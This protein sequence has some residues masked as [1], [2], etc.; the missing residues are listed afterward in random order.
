MRMRSLLSVSII[1]RAFTAEFD[2]IRELGLD[3]DQNVVLLGDGDEQPKLFAHLL[4]RCG[5]RIIRVLAPLVV[6]VATAAADR[7]QPGPDAMRDGRNR[8]E[9][10]AAFLAL[11][12]DRVN[13]V[14]GRRDGGDVDAGRARGLA[15]GVGGCGVD[16]QGQRR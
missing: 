5:R 11:C 7:E 4:P 10:A 13:H 6:G 16:G 14:V 8:L 9:R 12:D 1:S 2:D 3:A 15:H